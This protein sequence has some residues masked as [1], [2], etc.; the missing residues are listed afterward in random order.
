MFPSGH[1]LVS[2]QEKVVIQQSRCSHLEDPIMLFPMYTVL[3]PTVLD[4]AEI[5]PHEELKADGLLTLFREDMGKALFV[6]HQWVGSMHPDP[7]FKQFRV[8]QDALRNVACWSRE[9]T[10]GIGL[11]R[12]EISQRL[13]AISW[14]YL[15]NPRP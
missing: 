10:G 2:R 14:E 7:E 5:R 3:L 11:L 1:K 8:L 6:S 9:G 13:M 15:E 12:R 4:M